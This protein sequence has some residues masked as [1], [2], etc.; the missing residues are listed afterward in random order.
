MATLH[1]R[2]DLKNFVTVQ[3][4]QDTELRDILRETFNLAADSQ[5]QFNTINDNFRIMEDQLSDLVQAAE[6]ASKG[7]SPLKKSFKN[8][9]GSNR[10][11]ESLLGKYAQ[12]KK[13]TPGKGPASQKIRTIYDSSTF[14]DD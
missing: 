8:P 9:K 13:P 3:D 5:G 6:R 12:S 1:N 2:N 11:P 4:L 14:G 10:M 7:Q